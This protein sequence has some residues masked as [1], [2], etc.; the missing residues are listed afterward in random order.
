MPYTWDSDALMAQAV[1][2]RTYALYLKKQ[3][4]HLPFDVAATTTFQ[5]YGGIGAEKD[6][7]NRAVDVTRGLVL[8]YHDRLI[9]AYFHAN[10]AGHTEDA[11]KVWDVD[12]PYL[13]G[14]PDRFSKNLPYENWECYVSYEDINNCL[15]RAG[16]TLGNVS[17]INAKTISA[18]GRILEIQ[19][20]SDCGAFE[21]SGGRFRHCL[22]PMRIKST[23]FQIIEK[24]KGV[25]LRGKG[26]GHGVGMSQWGANQMAKEGF[27]YIKI[28]AHYY[29]G[30]VVTRV[31]I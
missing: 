17:A 1:A 5:V 25:I 10:S 31:D 16:H 27:H 3:N 24:N 2:S 26:Y 11:K 21:M 12:M 20:L 7:T 4:M 19:V 29:P 28:L 13:K 23:K 15:S 22:D 9:A 18:N 30:T 14:I 8:T 6:S